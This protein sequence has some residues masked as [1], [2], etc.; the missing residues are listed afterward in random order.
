ML[1]PLSVEESTLG[2]VNIS[3]LS[4]AMLNLSDAMRK[5]VATQDM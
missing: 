5:G 1:D 2:P 4:N 3:L